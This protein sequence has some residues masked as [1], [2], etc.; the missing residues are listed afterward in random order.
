M[1]PRSNLLVTHLLIATNLAAFVAGV[2]MGASVLGLGIGA[3]LFGGVGQ[4]HRRFALVGPAV[5]AGEWYRLLTS[6]FLHY[7]VIHLA[8]NMAALKH[9]GALLKPALGRIRLATLYGAALLAGSLGVLLLSPDA[10]TA[11]ASGAVFGLLG[12]IAVGLHLRGVQVWRTSIGSL[13]LLNLLFTFAVPGISIGG[14]LGGFAGGAL[15]GAVMLRQRATPRSVV[16]GAAAGAL[17]AA[18]AV[19]GSL[20]TTAPG[21]RAAA[22]DLPPVD[23][24]IAVS[25]DLFA[26]RTGGASNRSA[27]VLGPHADRAAAALERAGERFLTVTD[28][29]AEL[30]RHAPPPAGSEA[31]D[32]DPPSTPSFVS[33]VVRAPRGPWLFVDAGGTISPEMR[34]RFIEIL[35]EELEAAGVQEARLETARRADRSLR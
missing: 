3:S 26:E 27:I 21:E 9:L 10:Y 13:I 11:G 4:V 28:S 20:A 34:R 31:A 2:A 22:G 32:A 30:G 23:R 25:P 8:L 15:V 1:E 16:K 6:G 18:V 5:G 7:G 17:V 12:A 24:G 14:H 29:G 19:A 33:P 35:V